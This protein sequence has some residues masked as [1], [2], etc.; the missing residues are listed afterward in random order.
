MPRPSRSTDKLLISAGR[1]LLPET[2]VSGLTLRRVA[3]SAKVN[4]GM[5]HYHFGSKREFTRR[6]LRDIYEEFFQDFSMETGADA[7]PLE[8]L[9][10]ALNALARFA[11]DNRK[12]IL[13][14]VRDVLEEDKEAV[15]FAKANIPRHMEIIAGLVRD[16]QRR[17]DLKEMPIPLVMSFLLGAAAM[18]NVAMGVIERSGARKPF[19]LAPSALLPLFSSD[20][21]IGLRVDLALDAL[22][23]RAP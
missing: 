5:F 9:R 12:F 4:L 2:G 8:R 20:K 10:R 1:K 21:S 11:R 19:G 17:G 6:V 22:A 13:A 14:I 18:P 3:R 15:E 7:P 16:C 23:A